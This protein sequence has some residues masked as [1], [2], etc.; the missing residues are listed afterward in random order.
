MQV[1]Q[2]LASQTHTFNDKKQGFQ[3]VCFRHTSF[4]RK[5]FQK[6]CP[7]QISALLPFGPEQQPA[8]A[9]YHHKHWRMIVACNGQ[10]IFDL[11]L[12][13]TSAKHVWDD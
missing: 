7:Q 2:K 9:I 1:F 8:N 13:A 11:E 12:N 5:F 3:S 4:V 6:D 10:L